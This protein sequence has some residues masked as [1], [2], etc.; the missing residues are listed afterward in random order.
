[1]ALPVA[2]APFGGPEGRDAALPVEIDL[3]SDT[4]TLPSRAMR[5]FMCEAPVG[6]EQ[7]G[8]DPT[9]NLLQARMAALLGKEA[10]LY[11]PS[12]TMANQ[13]AIKCH[14]QPGDELIAHVLSHTLHYEVGGPAFHSGVMARG[15]E[16]P[17]GCFTPAQLEE[18]LRPRDSQYLP[19]SRL[20]WVEN[21]HN[22]AGGTVW[23]LAD[24]DAVAAW[25]HA[26]GLALHLDGARIFNAALASG[27][28]PARIA[29]GAD[30]V[31]VC[32]SKGLGCPG[33]A[34][35]AGPGALIARAR[36]YKQL[37]GGAMRQ[38]GILAAAAVYA[39]EHNVERLAED[40]RNARRL[41]E[42]LAAIP[43]IAV[44]TPETNMV[45]FTVPD[46]DGFHAAC[47]ER[48]LRFSKQVGNRL[49][50]VTHLDIS[51]EAVERAIA[52]AR[53]VA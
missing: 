38:A 9:V 47:L 5:A 46:V 39:L 31:T 7:K 34:V 13:I 20:V 21:T 49:R 37:F 42:G 30:T 48:G 32:F 29:A 51:A 4:V 12:A 35:L 36:K 28:A 24:L 16:G 18:V 33:G 15:L 8:E 50:A 11:M 19:S 27:V 23:T 14:T 25:T 45:Y 44:G 2:T 22:L 43:G 1:V 40:H 3:Y 10:A 41:A 26:H 17:R 53:A 52:I 6:D